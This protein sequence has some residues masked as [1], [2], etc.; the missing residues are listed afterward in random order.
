MSEFDGLLREHNKARHALNS[1][2]ITNLLLVATGTYVKR[3]E[4]IFYGEQRVA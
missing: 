1:G 2:R 3:S 4:S